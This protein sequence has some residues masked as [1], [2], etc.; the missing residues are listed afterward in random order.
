[1]T[2]TTGGTLPSSSKRCTD[3]SHRHQYTSV[4][5]LEDFGKG[6]VF[7]AK[8][9]VSA[10]EKGSRQTRSLKKDRSGKTY[11]SK[12]SR[13]QQSGS[14]RH[15]SST[16]RGRSTMRSYSDTSS[17]SSS[18]EGYGYY[19]MNKVGGRYGRK[20]ATLAASSVS[21]R[22][23]KSKSDRFYEAQRNLWKKGDISSNDSFDKT[24]GANRNFKDI[25]KLT[26]AAF[27]EALKKHFSA[28]GN[29]NQGENN[30]EV[31]DLGLK[32][33]RDKVDENI[34]VDEPFNSLS[35]RTE[36]L[37]G[38]SHKKTRKTKRRQKYYHKSSES[39][40]QSTPSSYKESR[41]DIPPE[42][43][44]RN[45]TNTIDKVQMPPPVPPYPLK[46][47]KSKHSSSKA[48][49]SIG[50]LS[51][52]EALSL[53]RKGKERRAHHLPNL[54][55]FRAIRQPNQLDDGYFK[56]SAKHIDEVFA[57]LQKHNRDSS[58]S[59][60]SPSSIKASER[61]ESKSG[62][63]SRHTSPKV[64]TSVGGNTRQN[65]YGFNKTTTSFDS[66]ISQQYRGIDR[67]SGLPL[68]KHPMEQKVSHSSKTPL[69]EGPLSLPSSKR[70]GIE[71][72]DFTS[73]RKRM[74]E[75]ERQELKRIQN[76][77]NLGQTYAN[78]NDNMA[79]ATMFDGRNA[80][81]IETSL[82]Y[83]RPHMPLKLGKSN[84]ADAESDEDEDNDAS[85]RSLRTTSQTKKVYKHKFS[86]NKKT[87][88]DLVSRKHNKSDST[89]SERTG[90]VK[91]K[92][93]KTEGLRNAKTVSTV[94]STVADNQEPVV[95]VD[96]NAWTPDSSQIEEEEDGSSRFVDKNAPKEFSSIPG[97]KSIP[98]EPT[99]IDAYSQG[100]VGKRCADGLSSSSHSQTNELSF[101]NKRTQNKE[102]MDQTQKRSTAHGNVDN[103]LVAYRSSQGKLPKS[104]TLRDELSVL[105]L[106]SK[107]SETNLTLMPSLPGSRGTKGKS[108]PGPSQKKDEDTEAFPFQ[109]ID[110]PKLF[111]T[112]PDQD[113]MKSEQKEPPL[114][115]KIS[116]KPTI[117]HNTETKYSNYQRNIPT[118]SSNAM[119]ANSQPN[120][121]S[122]RLSR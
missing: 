111:D 41:D 118:S 45:P 55:E 48:D 77:N 52:G 94:D 80:G 44:P 20:Y 36:V 103:R 90:N 33:Y 97:R 82:E 112:R 93:Y 46:T 21:R 54:E 17:T 91:E 79:S 9:V 78:N 1:M 65:L 96:P 68:F 47:Q 8:E 99:F 63:N 60:T 108:E 35:T 70:N 76:L 61:S 6:K 56:F 13:G 117:K 114:P 16:L 64:V 49:Y 110:P 38:S 102:H 88:K 67:M 11:Y 37:S 107:S 28:I 50:H 120:S 104:K 85:G 58:T 92:Y 5:L 71:V 53:N 25:N 26:A 116:N 75:L 57:S 23:T 113:Q 62:H 72:L 101:E 115:P 2:H 18:D 7:S 100:N 84:E 3:Q 89:G 59:H 32:T 98:V 86:N 74:L 42:L 109:T 83:T 31:Q 10:V 30:Q 19:E 15:Q 119:T 105:A 29:R 39:I 106:S 81:Y 14:A 66:N 95:N 122:K 22:R 12:S 69:P 121:L 27:S 73:N 43:P 34:Y 40:L 87:G 24:T 51:E 4:G